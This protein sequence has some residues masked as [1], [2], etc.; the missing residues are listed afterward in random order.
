MHTAFKS[1]QCKPL[2]L[3]VSLLLLVPPVLAS[4]LDDAHWQPVS[5][6]K[7]IRLPANFM[8]KTLQQNFNESALAGTISALDQQVA[9]QTKHMQALKQAIATTD[10]T[11]RVELR[12]QLLA[13]KSHYLQLVHDK[14]QLDARALETR[15]RVYQRVL[16]Q[17]RRERNKASDPV[18][19]KLIAKQKAAQKRL[20]KSIAAVDSAM[21]EMVSSAFGQRQNYAAQYAHNIAQLESLKAAIYQHPAN[22]AAAIAGE[23]VSREEY[24]RHLLAGI[25]SERSLQQQSQL[26]LTYM[27]KLVALD[28]QALE[29]ELSTG[30]DD[31]V[32]NSK[33]E[34]ASLANATDLFI[35]P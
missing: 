18:S 35:N 10:G 8:A 4:E 24:V 7:L 11:D 13:T 17:L 23:E 12:H 26:M 28:A 3:L 25:E 22:A 15:A 1:A 2:S 30:V 16:K 19:A 20:Q 29:H 6:E 5:S 9:A 31:D 33:Q 27:S 32:F 21:Q 14:Q 34:V